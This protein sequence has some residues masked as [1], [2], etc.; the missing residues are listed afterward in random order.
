MYVISNADRIKRRC[1]QIFQLL[2]GMFKYGWR[3]GFRTRVY[4]GKRTTIRNIRFM[5]PG[6]ILT[7]GDDVEIDAMS[8]EGLTLGN[9]CFIGRGSSMRLTNNISNLGKGV[10]IGNNFS[11]GD[12]SFFGANGGITIGDD[13]RMGQC[14]RF[15]AQNHKFDDNELIRLQGTTSKGISIGNNCWIGSGTVFLDG[16]KIG[17]GCV[18]AANSLITKEFPDNVVIMGQPGRIV[19]NRMGSEDNENKED[20]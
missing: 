1:R 4:C 9:D 18:V 13:V 15:H 7:L 12:Y 17:N 14:V 11:C 10:Y 19:R 16:A 20:N 8:R 5:N 3:F 6:S 2:R